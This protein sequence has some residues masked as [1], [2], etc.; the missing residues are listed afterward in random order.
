[1]YEWT[2][3]R[4][5]ERT[6][7]RAR[8]RARDQTN[9]RTNECWNKIVHAHASVCLCVRSLKNYLNAF[10]SPEPTILL[11][12][13]RNRDLWEQPFQA[14]AIDAHYV[15]PDGQ[16]SVISFVISKWL[17]PELSIP[18]VG[19]KDRRLWRREWPK[20]GRKRYFWYICRM[21]EVTLS[22]LNAVSF[23]LLLLYGHSHPQ[24][25]RSFWCPT[26][27]QIQHQKSA[28]HGLPVT[29]RMLR[30]KSGKSDWFWSQSI[31]VYKAIQNRNLV[32]QDQ[33]HLPFD[34]KFRDEFPEISIGKWYSLF[35]VWKT[36][37]VRLEFFND[38]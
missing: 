18:A 17:L 34:R 31:C 8:E 12:C 7:E 20:R 36:T 29:L 24:R 35:P 25:P 16:N 11:A 22:S 32:G 3:E 30:V 5:N 28:I 38:F 37:I 26:S 19:Q 21:W 1:M 15:K 27:G 14:C 13:G 10:S 4:T 23:K 6:N 9:E 33:G 2:D